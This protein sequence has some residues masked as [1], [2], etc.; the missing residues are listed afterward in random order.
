M[1]QRPKDELDPKLIDLARVSRVTKGGRHFSFRAVVVVGDKKGKVGVGVAKGKDVAQAMEKATSRAKKNMIVVPIHEETIPHEVIAK[2]GSSIVMLKPQK[3][4]RG[5][6]A[7]GPVRVIAEK[8]GIK[9]LSAKFISR[10]HNKLNNAMATI[11]ALEKL[12][13]RKKSVTTDVTP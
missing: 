4:G 11:V 10:T 12:R 2:S 1:Q 3:K 8:A 7:G 5:L 9:N 6:V 13:T